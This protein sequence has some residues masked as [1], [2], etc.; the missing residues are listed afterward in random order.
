MVS[1]LPTSPILSPSVSSSS[2]GAPS[3]SLFEPPVECSTSELL[4]G[5]GGTDAGITVSAVRHS[6]S[7]AGFLPG[8]PRLATVLA[9]LA[10][11]EEAVGGGLL[12][13]REFLA[14]AKDSLTLLHRVATQ[15]LALAD[16]QAFTEHIGIIY[17]K[18]ESNMSGKTADYIPA[19]RDA[20]PDMFGVSFCSVDGQFLEMGD[21]R[22]IFSVQSTSKAIT[23]ACALQ[24]ESAAGA[25]KVSEWC[26][27]EPSGRAF[28]DPSLLPDKRPY[29][30]AQLRRPFVFPGS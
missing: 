16:F 21:S 5:L 2:D 11:A 1:W 25:T 17:E 7:A 12:S 22:D 3:I 13:P 28:D 14:A 19:L 24:N 26:G 15:E 10:T 29:K 8:D 18:T 23:Y 4:Y 9:A 6:L 27:V 20:D 30:C